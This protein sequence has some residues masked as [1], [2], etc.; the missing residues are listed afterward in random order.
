[1]GALHVVEAQ[2]RLEVADQ[3]ADLGREAPGEREGL[4]D[5]VDSDPGAV[6]AEIDRI[7]ALLDDFCRRTVLL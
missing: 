6:T 3:P 2:V 7:E 4:A 1:M 5:L